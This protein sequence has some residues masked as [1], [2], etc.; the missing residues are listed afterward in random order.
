MSGGKYAC[1][2]ACGQAYIQ[3]CL[4]VC[5]RAGIHAN[6]PVHMPR[7]GIYANMPVCN[8]AWGSRL[9]RVMARARADAATHA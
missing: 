3:I 4:C 6:I 5:L 2:Y 8:C 1:V 9:A 7:A